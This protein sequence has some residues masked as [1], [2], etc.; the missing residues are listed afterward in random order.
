MPSV[1]FFFMV[2]RKAV[3]G[4]LRFRKFFVIE[5]GRTSLSCNGTPIYR[6][7]LHW[8]APCS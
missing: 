3:F 1:V 4:F 5:G 6:G 8:L 2:R 7:T